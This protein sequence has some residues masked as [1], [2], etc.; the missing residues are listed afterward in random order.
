MVLPT[1]TLPAQPS[2]FVPVHDPAY[3]QIDQL[4]GS[5]LVRTVLYGQRPYTQREIARL[6][7][8]ARAQLAQR[9][10][11][12]DAAAPP[13]AG[14]TSAASRRVLA[15]LAARFGDDPR[16]R[17]AAQRTLDGELAW[18]DS[19][20]RAIP[21]A[22]TGFIDDATVNPLL[23]ARAGRRYG[24]GPTVALEPRMVQP[25]GRHLL[26]TAAARLSAGGHPGPGGTSGGDP[27]FAQ[28]ALQEATLGTSFRNLVLEVGRQPLQW[29]P[30]LDGGLL[31]SASS[32]PLDLVRIRTEAPWRAPSLLKW[33][34]LLRGT[35]LLA[36]LGAGQN[37]PHAKVGAY[38]LSGQVTSYFELSAQVLVQ[39]GGR[40]SPGTSLRERVIDFIPAL[41]YSL[42]DDT[43]QFSNKLA[44]WDM[45]LRIPPLQ[46]LQLYWEA[47]FDDMDPRRW[48][49]TAWEDGGHIVGASMGQL[50]PGGALTAA[51]EFHHTGLRYY[52]HTVFASGVAF[53]GTLLGSP[54]GPM[55]DAGVVRLVHDAGTGRRAR[56]Q[57]AVERRG[58]DVWANA[59]DTPA[60]D[61]FRFVLVTPRPAEWRHRA[62]LELERDGVHGHRTAVHAG[63]E[64]VRDAGF[65]RGAGRWNMI[66]GLRTN[67]R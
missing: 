26:L 38:R 29:G 21:P 31:L 22:P 20:A 46:G 14:G 45:R 23:N 56:L 13:P 44:G 42:P 9:D 62:T 5:G 10:A 32:R 49:S 48:R 18:L 33:L 59:W 57:L 3:A 2:P 64:R 7:R 61:N 39:G 43:T 6:V 41:K 4:V 55:G 60:T 58:G 54:L 19:P 37:F 35:I 65:V 40:G 67:W 24:Q 16:A 27:R 8:E 15:Q 63:L 11:S 34:G 12:R 52:R 28:A 30:A 51:A 17:A 47:A 36:D 66:A 53:N 1:G 25:L 50:A